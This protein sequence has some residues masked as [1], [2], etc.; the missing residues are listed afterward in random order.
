MIH[1]YQFSSLSNYVVSATCICKDSGTFTKVAGHRLEMEAVEKGSTGGGDSGKGKGKKKKK[2]DK[3][4]KKEK[5]EK[6]KKDKSAKKG[7][8]K[9]N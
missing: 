9:G 3:K 2:K 8:K 7:K 5:K 6:K 4:G 1:K